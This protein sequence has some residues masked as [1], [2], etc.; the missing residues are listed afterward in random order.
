M[1]SY[2]LLILFIILVSFQV[3][4]TLRCACKEDLRTCTSI[5]TMQANFK[6]AKKICMENGGKLLMSS[7]IDMDSFLFNKTGNFW[8]GEEGDCLGSSRKSRSNNVTLNRG[9]DDTGCSSLCMSVSSNGNLTERSCVEEADGFLCA[10]IQWETCWELIT[11]EV[12]I[13]NKKVC[14]RDTCEHNCKNVPGGHMCSCDPKFR[15]SRKEPKRCEYFC[16]SSPCLRLCPTCD[17]PNGF[18]NDEKQCAD[19]DECN[20]N[21]NNCGQKCKNLIGHYKCSCNEGFMLVNKSQCLPIIKP[22]P[23]A[24]AF[25]TAPVNYTLNHAA[26]LTSG[27]YIGFTLFIMLIISALIGLLYYLRKRKLGVLFKNSNAPEVEL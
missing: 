27:G 23:L 15:P 2:R 25:V 14:R 16:D 18:I 20:S 24:A 10:G 11:V 22:T 4:H 5:H 3:G 1:D 6:T 19:I 21:H 9:G 13:L 12:Q 7:S 26:F 8:I 17:C